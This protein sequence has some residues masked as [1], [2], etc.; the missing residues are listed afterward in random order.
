M[1]QTWTSRALAG[2]LLLSLFL[3]LLLLAGCAWTPTRPVVTVMPGV[4]KPPDV[5]TQDEGQCRNLASQSTGAPGQAGAAG[6]PTG[7]TAGWEGQRR[8]DTAYLQCMYARG[9]VVPVISGSI[10]HYQGPPASMPPA[11]AGTSPR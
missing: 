6:A 7:P 8:F 4:N 10:Y 2:G 11:P 1:P 9:N 5:F 3:V